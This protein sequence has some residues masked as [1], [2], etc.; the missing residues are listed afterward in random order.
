[1]KQVFALSAVALS[2]VLA[3]CGGGGGDSTST[4]APA[5]T[6][7]PTPAPTPAPTPVP[8]VQNPQAGSTADVGNGVEGFWTTSASIANPTSSA[9]SLAI[10]A[11]NG[12]M[13][14]FSNATSTYNQGTLNFTGTTWAAAGERAIGSTDGTFNDNGTFVPKSSFTDPT[15]SDLTFDTYSLANALAVTQADLAGTWGPATSRI[16]VDGSGNFTGMTLQVG[17]CNVSGTILQ[18]DASSKKNL[19]KVLFTATQGVG[20]T[21]TLPIGSQFSGLAVIDLLNLGT[22]AKPSYARALQVLTSVPHVDFLWLQL[23]KS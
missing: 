1:M 5:T 15:S 7:T 23:Q 18:F 10:I 17:N 2:L 13:I 9:K 12:E 11:P 19:F 22:S 6:P 8:T 14:A 16:T 3:A 4:S 21:C 20:N